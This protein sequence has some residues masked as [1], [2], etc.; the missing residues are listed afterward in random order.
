MDQRTMGMLRAALL[1]SLIATLP[2]VGQ[3][4][5]PQQNRPAPGGRPGGGGPPNQGGQRPP[6]QG[7]PGGPPNNGGGG[8]QIQPHPNPRPQP[9]P[10]PKPQPGQPNRPP[11]RPPNQGRPPNNGGRPGNRPPQQRPP[12]WGRPPAHRPSY[13]FRPGDRD[14]L[15]RYYAS[16]FGYI[17]RAR[18]PIFLIGGFLPFADLA[19]LSPLPVSLYGAL[20]PIPPGCQ[21]GYWDGYVIVYDPMTGY[22]V[23]VVDLL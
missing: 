6:N 13:G 3:N 21:V 14:S 4:G 1:G 16:R 8:P 9:Q 10:G 20:P 2:A 11:N 17:N 5:Q 18:R 7:R 19:Y 15:R 23:S 22:I 12:Q